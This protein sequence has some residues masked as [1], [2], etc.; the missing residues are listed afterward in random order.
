MPTSTRKAETN[1]MKMREPDRL[2]YGM[3]RKRYPSQTD[4][5]HRKVDF[6]MQ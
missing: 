5:I 1:D 6:I 3:V 2:P 4:F